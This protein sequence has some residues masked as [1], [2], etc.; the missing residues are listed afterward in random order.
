MVLTVVTCTQKNRGAWSKT[1]LINS[2]RVARFVK[3]EA[4]PT[5][6]SVIDYR[7]NDFERG[8]TWELLVSHSLNALATRLMD[9]DTNR[10]VKLNVIETK[11]EGFARA[12]PTSTNQ[13]IQEIMI[14]NIV[15]GYDLA[16]GLH[17]YIWINC[18]LNFLRLKTTHTVSDITRAFS[19]SASLSA[20]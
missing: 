18:G 3:D 20:S 16:D 1:L 2:S 8:G 13:K 15:Y 6:K 19:T 5:T 4:N 12:K 10:L 17:S 9:D 14:D 11:W 7:I